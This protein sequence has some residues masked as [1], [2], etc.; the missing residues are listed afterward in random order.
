[1]TDSPVRAVW[2]E[3]HDRVGD[4][5]RVVTRF[6]PRGF[7]T[8]MRD[9]VREA[10]TEAEDQAIVD[11]TILDQ[12]RLSDF[13]E[14]VKAGDLHAVIRVFDDAWILAWPDDVR[15][16]SGFIVS[17]ERGGERASPDDVEWVIE[18]LNEAF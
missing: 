10:Y 3:V 9:D 8:R 13:Q 2:D 16:R 18:Y 7:E 17:L 11:D 6:E 14:E 5:L 15:A 1:M 12:M 4:D